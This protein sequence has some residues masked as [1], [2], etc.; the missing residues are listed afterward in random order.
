MSTTIP[1]KNYDD[2]PETMFFRV[3]DPSKP[4]ALHQLMHEM[5]PMFVYAHNDT[6][7]VR[8]SIPRD[9]AQRYGF[10]NMQCACCSSVTPSSAVGTVDAFHVDTA[11]REVG[12]WLEQHD[13]RRAVA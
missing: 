8:W 13:Y 3:P 2:I 10:G 9:V 5:A 6:D 4:S 11:W 7:W 12:P 1:R